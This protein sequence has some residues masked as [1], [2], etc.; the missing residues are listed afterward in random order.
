MARMRSRTVRGIGD[1]PRSESFIRAERHDCDDC[2]PDAW[3]IVNFVA[4][5]YGVEEEASVH[6]RANDARS[7]GEAMCRMADEIE[8]RV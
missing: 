3:V 4:D 5:F 6:L 7:P 1:A 2:R 8:A